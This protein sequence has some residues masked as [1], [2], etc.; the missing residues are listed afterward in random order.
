MFSAEVPREQ[1]LA[2][3]CEVVP[4]QYVQT[5][6]PCSWVELE[7]SLMLAVRS[8]KSLKDAGTT[9]SEELSHC[10]GFFSCALLLFLV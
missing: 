10:K 5:C 3:L 2:V 8:C 6:T 7:L 4:T 1:M 9:S